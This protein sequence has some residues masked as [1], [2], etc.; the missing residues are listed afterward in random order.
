[1]SEQQDVTD[2]TG[3]TAEARLTIITCALRFDGYAYVEANL[4]P[5][6][7]WNSAFQTLLGDAQSTG[8]FSPNPVENFAA[9]FYLH[10]SFYGHGMLP[11]QFSP[12]WYDMALYYLH[13]YRLP[14][15]AIHRHDS[16]G[17][18]DRRAKGA[19]ER[20]AAELRTLLRR[21]G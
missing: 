12:T 13:L 21:R 5:Q 10:R 6:T 3:L 9:N 11:G 17:D 14:T 4:P 7:S 2:A 8:K 15:P 20:A 1:M 16:A 18:W 19:A